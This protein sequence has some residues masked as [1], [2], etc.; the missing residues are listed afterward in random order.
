MSEG[1]RNTVVYFL[2][3]GTLLLG[4]SIWRS[5]NPPPPPPPE[6]DPFERSIK[7]ATPECQKLF[8]DQYAFLGRQS[9]IEERQ[10]KVYVAKSN[11][12][13]S[14]DASNLRKDIAEKRSCG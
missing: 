7:G 8:R 13:E 10:D 1:N 9:A 11:R 5:Y 6:E 4:V 3:V 14:A 12:I 2:V